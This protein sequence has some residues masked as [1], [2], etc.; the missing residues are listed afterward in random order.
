MPFI[1]HPASDYSTLYTTLNYIIDDGNKYGHSFIIVTFDQPLYL[2]AKE[3]VTAAEKNSSISKVIVRL[4]GFHLLMSFMG[5]IGYIMGGSGLKEVLSVIYA[6]NSVDH[7]LSGH[8]YSR[9]IRGHTLLQLALAHIIFKEL[10][11]HDE[12]KELLNICL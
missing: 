5:S 10:S 1:N 11:L 3:I 6:P 12:Q 8:A 4:G 7:M 9:A 2:K